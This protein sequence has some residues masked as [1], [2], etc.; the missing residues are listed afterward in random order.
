MEKRDYYE[1]LGVGRDVSPEELKK[2]YRRI[3]MK[4]HPDRNPG[5]EASARF[6]EATEAYEVLSDAEKREAYDRFGHAG[7]HPQA[8]SPGFDF[9]H[10]F[11]DI[12]GDVLGG[13]GDIFGGGRQSSSQGAHLRYR[14]ELSLEQAVLGD[15][16]RISIPHLVVCSQCNGSGAPPGVQP[17]RCE[18]CGGR[19]QISSQQGFFSMRQICRYCRGSGEI[20]ENPC[21]KCRGDGRVQDTESLEVKIPAGVD[22]GDR[23]R[24]GGKGEAGAQGRP[25]GDLFVD[26]EVRPHPV[27]AREGAHLYCTLTVDM[28]TAVLGGTQEAPTLKGKV[29]LKIPAGTQNGQQFRIAGKGVK[30]VRGGARGDLY[31]KIQVRIPTK[32]NQEQRQLLQRLQESLAGGKT[33]NT[34]GHTAQDDADK[35]PFRF[36][37]QRKDRK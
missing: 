26:V 6:K 18:S 19:G 29:D 28:L 13:F 12:F 25:S 31:C 2:S 32:L 7:V 14:L 17:R 9:S 30:P 27:F 34:K 16:V 1:V 24:L 37:R 22:N 4:N 21:K 5:D 3:A 15:K 8:A 20:I 11:S 35:K 10:A 36:N 23:I 33:S